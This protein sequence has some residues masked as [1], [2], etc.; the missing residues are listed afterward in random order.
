MRQAHALGQVVVGAKAQAGNHVEVGVARGEEH[1][2]QARRHRAQLPAQR[3]AALGFVTKPDVDDR[4]V[5][6]AC[7]EGIRGVLAIDEGRDFVAM[8][9]Q[10]LGVVG[11]NGGIVFD[12]G[13]AARHAPDYT[14]SRNRRRHVPPVRQ[15]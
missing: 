12:D 7:L 15:N 14:G 11:S 4:E 5:G 13:D 10:G 1:D 8:A 3:E 9:L 2:R 6:Q